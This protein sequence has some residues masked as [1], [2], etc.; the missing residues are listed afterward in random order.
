MLS[1][2]TFSELEEQFLKP[3]IARRHV[4]RE[5]IPLEHMQGWELKDGRLAN[6][7]FEIIGTRTSFE[8]EPD[9]F[10]PRGWDQ[11]IYRQ[12]TG[13]LVLF[14]DE[15]KNV[16][17]QAAF[18]PGNAARGYQ[19]RGLTLVNSCKFSPGNLAFLKSQ[20][21]IP[22]LSDL[23]D[24]PDANTL[25]SHLAPGDSGRADKQNEHHLIQLPRTVLEEAVRNLPA[26]QPEFYALISLSVLRECYKQ[27]LVNEH[28][29]D[30]TSMLLFQN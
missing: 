19:N 30:L 9:G 5:D 26:P 29:R 7:F 17:V 22:P 18:E 21:K 24:H 28:L 4:K 10:Q 2:N 3:L 15:H 11:P 23:V 14:V 8:Q 16:L 20:G 13:T 25:F 12:G 6:S 1:I 27:A